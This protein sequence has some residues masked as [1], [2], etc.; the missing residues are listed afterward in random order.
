MTSQTR[1][2]LCAKPCTDCKNSGQP[3]SPDVVRVQLELLPGWE[4]A[5][6]GRR[7]YK[8]WKTKNFSSAMEFLNRVAQL[9]EKEGHHPDL[10]LTG[11]CHVSIVLSTHSIGGLSENDFILAAK[12]DGL[13]VPLTS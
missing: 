4:A 10:H 2:Q 6:D 7:I 5:D 11:Y 13:P 1:E 8:N 3:V 12:I 9:A